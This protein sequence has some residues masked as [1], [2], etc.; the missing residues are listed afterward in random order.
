MSSQISTF[1]CRKQ[2]QPVS[3]Q[4]SSWFGHLPR[5]H[6]RSVVWWGKSAFYPISRTENKYRFLAHRSVRTLQGFLEQT[7]LFYGYYR[8]DKIS[9]SHTT[10]NLALAY[11]LVTVAYLFLSLI[12]IV[13]R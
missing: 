3:Q 2:M 9:F 4:R 1:P 6:C 11:L 10:Y 13:K 12:W 5:A 7:Y 8:A